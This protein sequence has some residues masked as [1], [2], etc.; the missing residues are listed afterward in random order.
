MSSRPAVLESF[1]A[2]SLSS[3]EPTT[4]K[5]TLEQTIRRRRKSSTLGGDPRGDSG[6]GSLATAFPP[7]PASSASDSPTTPASTSVSER[8]G[9]ERGR[10]R[11]HAKTLLKRWKRLSLRHTWLN[12]LIIVLAVLGGY[13]VS[14]GK[15]N[16]LRHAIYLSYPNP[17]E[18]QRTRLPKHVGEVTQ[19]G[20]GSFDFVFVAFYTVV[21]TFFREF[22]MQRILRPT[23]I[24][25]GFTQRNRQSRFMEQSFTAIYHGAV[26][27]FGLFVMSRTSIWWF[28]IDGMLEEYPHRAN[29][30][31]FKAFYLLQAS[32]W[33]ML[34]LVL[35]LQL[36][37]PRKD[38]KELVLHHVVTLSLIW[39]SYRYHFTYMGIAVFI[40]HD[41]S[42]FFLAVSRPVNPTPLSQVYQLTCEQ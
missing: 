16:P 21:M 19:Y 18:Y 23:A 22:I 35:L 33:T 32:Y 37:K 9:R 36:E 42:D 24:S 40:T 5:F 11:K 41:V 4:Q 39:S 30:S 38:Y 26:S 2:Y 3:D 12:P 1:P 31:Y 6:A 25:L 28:N 29:E 7:R 20:K 13:F 34:G 8:H 17:P 10:K 14:P 27:V 15:H